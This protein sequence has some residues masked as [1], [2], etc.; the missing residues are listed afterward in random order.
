[1][2]EIL[3]FVALAITVPALIMGWSV[4]VDYFFSETNP[5]AV[6]LWWVALPLGLTSFVLALVSR[7]R[8]WER[9]SRGRRRANLALAVAIVGAV[10]W[11]FL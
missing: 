2:A 4:P 6:S 1:M 7:R 10:V 9:R 3:A 5:V 11:A 8:E